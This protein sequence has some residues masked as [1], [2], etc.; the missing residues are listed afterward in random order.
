MRQIIIILLLMI[1]CN[2]VFAIDITKL[3]WESAIE[4]DRYQSYQWH[5]STKDNPVRHLERIEYVNAIL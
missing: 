4:T 1:F 2:N 3:L 5:F